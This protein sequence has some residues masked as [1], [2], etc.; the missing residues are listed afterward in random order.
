[1]A[2]RFVQFFLI[3]H[4]RIIGAVVFLVCFRLKLHIIR[5]CPDHPCYTP[6]ERSHG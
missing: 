6:K 3:D 5:T 2:N 4:V 1:M